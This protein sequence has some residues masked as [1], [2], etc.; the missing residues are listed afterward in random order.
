MLL[1][2]GR[3]FDQT[4]NSL[5]NEKGDRCVWWTLVGGGRNGVTPGLLQRGENFSLKKLSS[6]SGPAHLGSTYADEAPLCSR[7]CTWWRDF[8]ELKSSSCPQRVPDWW[9]CHLAIQELSLLPLTM[10]TFFFF[11]FVV[12]PMLFTLGVP[13]P[14]DI[15]K[16]RNRVL[17]WLS[18][19]QNYSLSPGE[20]TLTLEKTAQ[21]N[22]QMNKQDN[23]QVK[24]TFLKSGFAFD[25]NKEH[26]TYHRGRKFGASFHMCVRS[27][28][29]ILPSAFSP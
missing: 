22:S 17:K 10:L 7:G 15:H 29:A 4:Q 9:F 14:Q 23:S 28:A 18:T 3:I 5:N 20:W 8:S 13:G 6:S 25:Q 21:A 16:G 12:K 24:K 1:L 11:F 2:G 19:F 27:F 26:V